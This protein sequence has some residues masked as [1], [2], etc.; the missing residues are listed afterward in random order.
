MVIATKWIRRKRVGSDMN[1]FSLNKASGFPDPPIYIHFTQENPIKDVKRLPSTN[2]KNVFV[3]ISNTPI[4]N[5]LKIFQNCVILFSIHDQANQI[6]EIKKFKA[7]YVFLW[8]DYVF[9]NKRDF[10][11]FVKN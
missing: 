3:K 7:L 8:D 5:R 9:N 11:N 10:Y 6:I 4:D 1:F 2:C